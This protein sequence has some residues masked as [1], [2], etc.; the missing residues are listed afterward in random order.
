[1][2]PGNLTSQ[3]AASRKKATFNQLGLFACHSALAV[4][5]LS[6]TAILRLDFHPTPAI[7]FMASPDDLLH[8]RMGAINLLQIDL[9]QCIHCVGLS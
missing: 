3:L 2:P 5:S 7:L 8:H 6:T 1:L 4:A 9:T